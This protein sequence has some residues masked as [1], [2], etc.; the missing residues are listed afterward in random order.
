MVAARPPPGSPTGSDQTRGRLRGLAP[1]ISRSV[2]RG[3]CWGRRPPPWRCGAATRPRRAGRATDARSAAGTGELAVPALPGRR[4]SGTAVP[5]SVV[6]RGQLRGRT[7]GGGDG[8]A[9]TGVMGPEHAQGGRR[10]MPPWQRRA[11]P[12]STRTARTNAS[13]SGPSKNPRRPCG[14]RAP[15]GGEAV[16][17]ADDTPADTA[18]TMAPPLRAPLTTP[19]GAPLDA[20]AGR[21]ARPG[22]SRPAIAERG[23]DGS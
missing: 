6:V 14:C 20:A 1:R 15:P 2:R 10:A 23:P 7:G 4:P 22:G 19:A 18:P 9:I 13:F 3:P 16:Q 11:V 5:L 21:T 17:A 12:T 8:A